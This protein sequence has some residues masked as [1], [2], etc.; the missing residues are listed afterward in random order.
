MDKTHFANTEERLRSEWEKKNTFDASIR[1]NDNKREYVFFDGPPFA[2]GLQRS[3]R[4][5]AIHPPFKAPYFWIASMQYSEHVG[6][7]LHFEGPI[8]GEMQ[9]L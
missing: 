4:L 3:I 7:Y 5:N 8:R 2:N 1:Q 9:A 6:M